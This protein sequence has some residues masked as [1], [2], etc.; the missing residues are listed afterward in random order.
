MVFF[1]LEQNDQ[2]SKRSYGYLIHVCCIAEEQS[3][4]FF[5]EFITIYPF[6]FYF[7]FF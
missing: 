5:A 1:D 3:F 7:L 6:L 4:V 2:A